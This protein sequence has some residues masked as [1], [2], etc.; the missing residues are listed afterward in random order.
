LAAALTV[1]LAL[2]GCATTRSRPGPARLVR[3][4]EVPLAIRFDNAAHDYVHVYLVGEKREWLLG[5][6]EIGARATLRI[7]EDALA[8]AG[9]MRLAVL[10]G[11]RRASQVSGDSRAATTLRQP[12]AAILSQRWTFSQTAANEQL[13]SLPR[14]PLPR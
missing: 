1:T 6:V 14:D 4:D 12:I 5:R 9:Q 7:P 2:A 11:Q 3:S 8:D 13:T 10:E